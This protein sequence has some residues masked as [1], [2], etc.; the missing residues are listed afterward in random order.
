MEA[1]ASFENIRPPEIIIAR[2]RLIDA[3]QNSNP[4]EAAVIILSHMDDPSWKKVVIKAAKDA[5]HDD[6]AKILEVCGAQSR[7]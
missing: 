3:I 6:I 2:A 7:T 5:G 4:R 1:W